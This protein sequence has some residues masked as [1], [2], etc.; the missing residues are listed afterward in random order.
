MRRLDINDHL[1]DLSDQVRCRSVEIGK[2]LIPE[3]GEPPALMAYRPGAFRICHECTQS[4]SERIVIFRVINDHRVPIIHQGTTI[5]RLAGDFARAYEAGA[6]RK[7]LPG[8]LRAVKGDREIAF[9]KAD[10]VTAAEKWRY[11]PG[12]HWRQYPRTLR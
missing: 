6:G 8:N 9:Q 11:S 12:R 10:C 7:H 2:L 3:L 5:K 4:G 1:L